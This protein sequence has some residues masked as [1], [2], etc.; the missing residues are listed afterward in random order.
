VLTNPREGIIISNELYNLYEIVLE[1]AV[2]N[3]CASIN[4][5]FDTSHGTRSLDEDDTM[6]EPLENQGDAIKILWD[7]ID[8][9]DEDT[10]MESIEQEG[11][12]QRRLEEEEAL[13]EY[14]A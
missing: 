7:Q 11:E 10:L 4:H 2:S 12:D 3:P 5:A 13:L 9:E 14:R 1:G 8:N 6:E